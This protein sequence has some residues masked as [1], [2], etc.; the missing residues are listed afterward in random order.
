[1]LTRDGEQRP[2]RE[3]QARFAL[4]VLRELP[5]DGFVLDAEEIWRWLRVAG[6]ERDFLAA[7]AEP[8]TW[9]GRLRSLLPA[10]HVPSRHA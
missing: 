10:I 1:M 4:Y 6:D 7:T 2:S 8:R 3:L 5:H 9:A